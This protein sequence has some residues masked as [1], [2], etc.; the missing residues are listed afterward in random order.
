MTDRFEMIDTPILG[1]KVIRRLP[2]G[3]ERGKLERLFCA[4]E[5]GA[6]MGGRK[7]AQVNHTLTAKAGTVRGMHFQHPPHA[8]LK[9][10]SC[11]R[12]EVFDVAVDLRRES[13]T[14]LR[15]HAEVLRPDNQK[16]LLIPEGFA[17]GVQ[18]LSDDCELLY[19]TTAAYAPAAEGGLHPEDP[20]LAIRWPRPVTG[21]SPRDG[22]HRM[23]GEDFRGI[24]V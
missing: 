3:D 17:H 14:L 6:L 10:V 20:K 23:L 21:L 18:A 5:L 11:L 19:F 1:L 4:E 2:I 7:I 13:P 9:L 12:G 24:A 15:W 22:A 16:A 8:E